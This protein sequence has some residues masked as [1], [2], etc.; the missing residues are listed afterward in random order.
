MK[1]DIFN[2][3]VD[4]VISLF[5]ITKEEFFLKS[6][7]RNLVDARYLVYYLCS[8][9]P[10]QASYIQ[11]FMKNNNY[12]TDHTL[13]LHG[14]KVTK[15]KVKEDRDYQSIIKEIDNAVFI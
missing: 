7:K 8:E 5:G 13:I 14:I 9:R 3:Y 2:Q 6:R 4:R 10:I 15:E 1:E 12:E 11:N